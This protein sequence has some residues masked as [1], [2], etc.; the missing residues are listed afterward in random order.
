MLLDI[1]LNFCFPNVIFGAW[2][3]SNICVES[4]IAITAISQNFSF[5]LFDSLV[6]LWT[7]SKK[8]QNLTSLSLFQVSIC[9]CIILKEHFV[10]PCVLFLYNFSMYY[11]PNFFQRIYQ[12]LL[13]VGLSYPKTFWHLPFN[14]LPSCNPFFL[15]TSRHFL[16]HQVAPRERSRRG[17]RR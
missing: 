2:F 3:L 13:C 1:C 4:V 7:C 10:M 6:I 17:I 12:L 11:S 5:H 8:T 14:F 15:F 9:Q 16:F